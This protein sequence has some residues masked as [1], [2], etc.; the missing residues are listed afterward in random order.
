M[1][2]FRGF[3]CQNWFAPRSEQVLKALQQVAKLDVAKRAPLERAVLQ[4]AVLEALSCSSSPGNKQGGPIASLA[5]PL[6][7]KLALSNDERAALPTSAAVAEA[8][9]GSPD[10]WLRG[11][12]KTALHTVGD[13]NTRTHTQLRRDSS[14]ADLVRMVLVGSDGT[15]YVSDV[16]QRL[17]IRRSAG[18]EIHVC[19]A[20]V[21]PLSATCNRAGSLT[22]LDKVAGER[23][24]SGPGSPPC[25]G[26]HFGNRPQSAPFGP[27]TGFAVSEPTIASVRAALGPLL[28]E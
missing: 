26:C 28:V 21:D 25:F 1:S 23:A 3:S 22:P 12:P 16:A 6:I 18:D 8:W 7:K 24:I 17:V 27:D 10:T 4:N 14:L 11:L 9:L 19:I 20:V 13:G 2:F 5:R 15:P